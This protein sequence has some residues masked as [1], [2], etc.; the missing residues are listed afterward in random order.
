MEKFRQTGRTEK[1]LQKAISSRLNGYG[2][3]VICLYNHQANC[4]KRYFDKN[5]FVGKIQVRFLLNGLNVLSCGFNNGTI[6]WDQFTLL[7]TSRHHKVFF[8]HTVIE[9]KFPEIADDYNFLMSV[10]DN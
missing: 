2:V 6:I 7:G 3:T 10:I 9:Y 8:D 5:L 1:M 4:F